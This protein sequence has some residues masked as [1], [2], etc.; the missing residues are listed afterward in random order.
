MGFVGTLMYIEWVEISFNSLL[1]KKIN[2][3]LIIFDEQVKNILW[4]CTPF[5]YHIT[6]KL[7]CVWMNHCIDKLTLRELPIWHSDSFELI[8][9]GLQS[10]AN[11]S[12][13]WAVLLYC[14]YYT[15]YTRNKSIEEN[16]QIHLI[17]NSYP[18]IIVVDILPPI[19][20]YFDWIFK[21]I[22]I[23]GLRGHFLWTILWSTDHV[24]VDYEVDN[25]PFRPHSI[26]QNGLWYSF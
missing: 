9:L 19:S 21:S 4:C 18:K 16:C 3:L 17:P 13:R 10:H 11:N 15:W 1:I 12:G 24:T 20:I 8:F 7:W 22:I 23:T 25:I 5:S 2:P 14:S 6:C 26:W